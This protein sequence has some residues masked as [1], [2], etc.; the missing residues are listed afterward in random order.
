MCRC[1]AAHQEKGEQWAELGCEQGAELGCEQ[2]AEL[3]CERNGQS[4]F[5]FQAPSKDGEAG[6]GGR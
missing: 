5:E 3:D 2:W 4:G 1:G 6:V